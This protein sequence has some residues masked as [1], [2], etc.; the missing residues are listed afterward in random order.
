MESRLALLKWNINRAYSLLYICYDH[1][2]LGTDWSVFIF[3]YISKTASLKLSAGIKIIINMKKFNKDN[4]NTLIKDL[5][6]QIW[7]R[8]A[9][10]GNVKIVTVSFV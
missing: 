2:P 5:L 9:G 3:P 8:S 6:F 7:L 1:L 4:L 10:L